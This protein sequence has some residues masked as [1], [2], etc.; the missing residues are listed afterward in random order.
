MTEYM[1]ELNERIIEIYNKTP[2]HPV[3]G[4]SL[5]SPTDRVIIEELEK[6]RKRLDDM[7]SKFD[8]PL[9]TDYVRR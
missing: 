6:I 2:H 8:I 5:I 7:E 1:K 3:M 9:P 4:E